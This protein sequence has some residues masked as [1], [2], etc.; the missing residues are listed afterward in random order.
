MHITAQ[1]T[2]FLCDA[3]GTREREARDEYRYWRADRVAVRA[4]RAAH[5]HRHRN[6]RRIVVDARSSCESVVSSRHAHHRATRK[7]LCDAS[8]TRARESAR[9]LQVLARRQSCC[10]SNSSCPSPSPSYH[11]ANCSRR[12]F[13]MREHHLVSPCTSLRSSQT[14][15]ACEGESKRE[16]T[17]QPCARAC[18]LVHCESKSCRSSSSP[19]TATRWTPNSRL[20]RAGA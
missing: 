1:L 17:W 7:F 6:I 18:W 9:R 19:R 16:S 2:D 12:S 8:G 13:F 10:E 5:R 3:R 20:S 11:S 4:N 15:C 14:F